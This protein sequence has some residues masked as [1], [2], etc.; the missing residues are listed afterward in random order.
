MR[1]LL[2]LRHAKAAPY[3]GRDDYGRALT[4]GGREDA[5]QIGDLIAAR[6]LVPDIVVYSTA[7]RTR[8][9]AEIAASR[10]PKP[11]KLV[12]ENG[13]YD[14]TRTMILVLARRLPDGARVAMI[15]GHNPGIGELANQLAGGGAAEDRLRMAA[16]YPTSGLAILD[17]P[18]AGWDEIEPNSARL[19]R[20]YCPA[21]L[22]L[23]R[24]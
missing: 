4:G 18:Q 8:Q 19:A 13:L 16:K 24:A 15:V 12:G 11:T 2:L 14:A 7:E 1:R 3:A 6:D 22:S 10:W 17:F 21:D 9:T 23:G 5:R 20:F